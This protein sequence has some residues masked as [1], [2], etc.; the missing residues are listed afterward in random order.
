MPDAKRPDQLP[1]D[2]CLFCHPD[3]RRIKSFDNGF[4]KVLA[5]L[6]RTL[7]DIRVLQNDIADY[8]KE[9]GF[10]RKATSEECAER[11]DECNGHEN[12]ARRFA[13]DFRS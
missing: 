4:D 9:A 1:P 8:D 7:H 6:T 2:L 10:M 13:T 12:V 3:G 11:C 5:D